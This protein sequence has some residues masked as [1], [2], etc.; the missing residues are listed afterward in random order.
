MKYIK[1]YAAAAAI[2]FVF[3][4]SQLKAEASQ[5][6][7]AGSIGSDVTYV[8]AVLQKMGYF[9]T[10]TTGYYGPVTASAV[11]QFQRD[12]GIQ[13]TGEV[14]PQTANMINNAVKMAH[15]VHGEA[16]GESYEGQVAVAAVILNRVES[17]DFPNSIDQVIFQRNAFTAVHDGQY[18]LYPHSYAYHAVKDAFLGW[19]PSYGAVYYYNPRIATNQWIFTRT[20]IK[21]IGNHRFAF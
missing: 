14:G 6:L 12:F 20:T 16:R 3:S 21:D 4:F 10:N 1:L 2:L 5:L 7:R 18:Y 19:D 11:E 13:A 17:K 8:Q 15:V 9:N